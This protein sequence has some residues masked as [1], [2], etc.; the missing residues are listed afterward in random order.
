LTGT[1]ALCVVSCARKLSVDRA[2]DEL[3]DR[4]AYALRFA[5]EALETLV[6][7]QHLEAAIEHVHTLAAGMHIPA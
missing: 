2:A 7:D 4:C 1:F 6:V 3:P 5:G